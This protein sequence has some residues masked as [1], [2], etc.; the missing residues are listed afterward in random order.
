[1]GAT[2]RPALRV[3]AAEAATRFGDMSPH[4]LSRL[5]WALSSQGC[6]HFR[7]VAPTLATDLRQ[8]GRL[9]SLDVDELISVAYAIAWA[10]ER[11]VLERRF[12]PSHFGRPHF[13]RRRGLV[14]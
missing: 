7:V 12:S 14:R 6:L 2:C 8:P 9:S 4:E 5:L 3:L 10:F 13:R 1:M 11:A